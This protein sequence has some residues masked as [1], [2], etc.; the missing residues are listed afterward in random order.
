MLNIRSV[1]LVALA[2][3]DIADSARRAASYLW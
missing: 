1:Q 3:A 2:V